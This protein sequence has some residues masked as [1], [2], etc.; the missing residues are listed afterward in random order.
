MSKG[1]SRKGVYERKPFE[2][3]RPGKS[4]QSNEPYVALYVTFLTSGAWRNLSHGARS[5]Y[6]YMKLQYMGK[7]NRDAGL[8]P[9]QFYFNRAMYEGY[10]FKNR[11]QF[12]K[13]RD[14]LIQ[15][16]FIKVIECGRTTRTKSIYAFSADWQEVSEVQK[17]QN[18]GTQKRLDRTEKL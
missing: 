11:N 10:G 17:V 5:L 16:G 2:T 18:K 8:Q 13:W 14:E 4:D 12:C 3:K 15:Q 7:S 9:E 6:T 1:R